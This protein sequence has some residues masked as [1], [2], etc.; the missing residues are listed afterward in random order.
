MSNQLLFQVTT[1]HGESCGIPPQIDEQTFPDVY[2]SC[3]E[4]QRGEQV[5]FLY[6]YKQ[7]CGIL[8]MG[9]AGWEHPYDVVHGKVAGLVLN[10]LEQLWL[11]ACWEASAALKAMR[12]PRREGQRREPEP[13]ER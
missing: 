7:E 3:F 11:S 9:D 13:Y 8:Y 2:R 4:N 5:I 12:E 6:D 1:H 10:R